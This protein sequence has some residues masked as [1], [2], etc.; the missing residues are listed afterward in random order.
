MHPDKQPGYMPYFYEAGHFLR[1]GLDR[2]PRRRARDQGSYAQNEIPTSARRYFA[3]VDE[4]I[5]EGYLA[6]PTG[7]TATALISDRALTAKLGL[8]DTIQ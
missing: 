7:D 6:V 8:E 5:R 4:V 1:Y 3:T 2:S